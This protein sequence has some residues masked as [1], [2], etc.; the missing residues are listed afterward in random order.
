M[1]GSDASAGRVEIYHD[2][3]WGTICD[4]WWGEPDATVVCRQLGY[5]GGTALGRAA[6]GAGTGKIWLD[7]VGCTGAEERLQDCKAT[8]WGNHNCGHSE[9]ASVMCDV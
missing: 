2:N 1:N 6:F 9:D 4:D 3:L 5:S 7:N 8:H